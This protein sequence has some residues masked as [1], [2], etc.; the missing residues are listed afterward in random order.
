MDRGPLMHRDVIIADEGQRWL[1]VLTCNST[2]TSCGNPTSF[3]PKAGTTVALGQG[4]EP[5][6]FYQLTYL[7]G[8]LTRITLAGSS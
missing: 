5:D 8:T 4:P 2:F 7:P 1:K 6:S 3:D